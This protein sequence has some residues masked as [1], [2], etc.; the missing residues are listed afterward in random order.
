MIKG[1]VMN[2]VVGGLNDKAIQHVQ[3]VKTLFVAIDMNLDLLL[4]L[5]VPN[6]FNGQH[7]YLS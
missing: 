4:F 3:P 7:Y 1:R 6:I 2:L 5:P